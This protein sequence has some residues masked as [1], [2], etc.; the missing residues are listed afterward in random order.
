MGVIV[1]C[2]LGSVNS[3]AKADQVASLFIPETG[4]TRKKTSSKP[5][6]DSAVAVL[7]DRATWEHFAGAYT[8]EDGAMFR[9]SIEDR[10]LFWINPSGRY[11]LVARGKDT[12]ELFADPN[13][14][15]AFSKNN[16]GQTIS[17]EYWPGPNNRH[18]WK[19]DTTALPDKD[20]LTYT[21]TYYCPEL[22]CRYTISLKD[23]RLFMGSA[24]YNDE[25]LTL[26][27]DNM[28]I[29]WWWMSNMKV[30]RDDHAKI[31]GFEV[32]DGRVQHLWFK[33]EES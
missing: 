21:G 17:E 32:N 26:I 13:V 3:Q 15:F 28:R 27:E 9:F 1:F 16:A 5:Y 20:L 25:P 8:S 4:G 7:R 23:H 29:G 14:W 31:T 6:T 11:L 12:A 33:K 24:K 10:K 22:D 19:Y 30:M 18:L 2:N